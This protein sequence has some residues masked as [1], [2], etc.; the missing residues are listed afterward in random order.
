VALQTH[1]KN[2]MR[3]ELTLDLYFKSINTTVDQYREFPEEVR[4]N[5]LSL[6]NRDLDTGNGTKAAE[7][8]LTDDACAKLLSRL[9]DK[10]FDLTSEG[11]RDN[12]LD[13]YSDLSSSDRDQEGQRS[14]AGRTGVARPVEVGRSAANSCKQPGTAIA[15]CLQLNHLYSQPAREKGVDVC[16]KR[17]TDVFRVSSMSLDWQNHR[18]RRFNQSLVSTQLN[19]EKAD[20]PVPPGDRLR[21]AK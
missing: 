3:E 4:T 12:V 14:L 13:C 20:S 18:Q 17:Q 6:P 15:D 7:Y 1:K 5:S 2:M 21:Q 19:P 8:S 10:K 16:T 9:S 11:L